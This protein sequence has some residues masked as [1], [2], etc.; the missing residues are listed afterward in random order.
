MKKPVL[1]LLSAMLLL[2]VACKKKK[3]PD[4]TPLPATCNDVP[5]QIMMAGDTAILA[6]AFTPNGDGKNDYIFLISGG[7]PVTGNMHIYWNDSLVFTTTDLSSITAGW[8]GYTAT[9]DTFPNGI[10]KAHLTL[11]MGGGTIDTNQCFWLLR[12]AGV[13]GCI[14]STGKNLF[15][16]DQF[17]N[18]NIYATG[19]NF[20]N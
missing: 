4:A 17:G 7:N 16:P 15:F 11:N 5:M 2:G 20:C 14:D 9:G 19:E 6:N 8:S 12:P 3:D 18:G 10:Y 1:L 13:G